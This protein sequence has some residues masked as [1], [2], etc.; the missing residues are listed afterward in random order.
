MKEFTNPFGLVT[1]V[2]DAMSRYLSIKHEIS[3][4]ESELDVLKTMIKLKLV[5]EPKDADG[6]RVLA[7]GDFM[8]QL[9]DSSRESFN[10]KNA[11]GHIK[12]EVLA[13]FIKVTDFQTLLVKKVK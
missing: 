4:R 1:D 7:Q 9:V 3:L 2:E 6:K 12:E 10:L 5:L 11:R 13:P 8:C